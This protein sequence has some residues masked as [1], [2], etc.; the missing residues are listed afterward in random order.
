MKKRTG[1]QLLVTALAAALASATLFAGVALADVYDDVYGENADIARASQ[2]DVGDYGGW[3]GS[4]YYDNE[5]YYSSSSKKSSSSTTTP[6]D[7]YGDVWWDGKTARWD[8]IRD[9][10]EKYEVQLK[11]GSST[12]TTIRTTS[13]SYS[14]SSNMKTSGSYKFRVR[15]VKGSKHGGWSDYSDT[16]HVSVSSSSSSSSSVTRSTS[17]TSNG[18]VGQ[19]AG[20]QQDSRGWWYL[21]PN[22]SYAVNSWQLING[23][24]YY[25]GNDG[26]MKTGW[27]TWNGKY[28]FCDASGAMLANT[29]TPDGFYVGPDGAWVQ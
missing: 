27:I 1:R 16:T 7:F 29:T 15:L 21:F 19:T 13:G 18:P 5:D 12:V 26:Y 24:W 20:W 10:G 23:K 6:D 14:F 9:S 28:Y 25:F 3:A 8:K 22:G 11:R 2:W 17:Y 4:N